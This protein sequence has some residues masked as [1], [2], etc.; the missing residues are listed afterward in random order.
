MQAMSSEQ[1]NHHNRTADRS[2]EPNSVSEPPAEIAESVVQKQESPS[3]KANLKRLLM[4]RKKSRF[5]GFDTFEPGPVLDEEMEDV[6]VKPPDSSPIAAEKQPDIASTRRTRKRS[7][8]VDALEAIA[9]TAAALKRRKI[10]NG[11]A[12]LAGPTPAAVAKPEKK[13]IFKKTTVKRTVVDESNLEDIAAARARDE[14]EQ[15]KLEEELK[16]NPLTK[17]DYEHIRDIIECAEIEV[18]TKKLQIDGSRQWD[19]KWNGRKN[20]KTFKKRGQEVEPIRGH[21]VIVRLEETVRSNLAIGAV[22]WMGSSTTTGDARMQDDDDDI[23][24]SQFRRSTRPARVPDPASVEL[25]PDDYRQAV[26]GDLDSFPFKGPTPVESSAGSRAMAFASPIV[27]TSRSQV[28][29]PASGSIAPPSKRQ[30]TASS[31]KLA[32]KDDDSSAGSDE[33]VRFKSFRNRR[34]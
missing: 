33:E 5:R 34:K 32:D 7:P 4:N 14:E 23:D 29:R 28:K 17:Q 10:A 13:K 31:R 16:K 27:S 2:N 6:S 12:V 24:D 21:K 30:A 22:R 25:P 15:E 18:A 26:S 11:T 3:S 20:F 19:D 1:S 8:S 9:P